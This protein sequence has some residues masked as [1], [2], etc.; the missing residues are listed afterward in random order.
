MD[1]REL[2]V[3]IRKDAITMV[4]EHHASHIASALSAVDMLA[5]LYADI[6]RID[7]HNPQW[8]A[9]DRFILSKGHA[10]VAVYAVLAETGFFPKE[11]LAQY[12]TNGSVYSGHV[13]H[14]GVPGVEFS[15]GSLGHGVCVAA[16]MALAAKK[17]QASYRVYTIIGDGECDEGSVWE[18]ALF[19]RQ[20]Q[21][22]N[23]I[24]LVDHNKMQAMGSCADIADLKDLA[25][26]WR[27][28]GWHVIDVP[29]GNDHAQLRKAL[30]S[31]VPDVPTC[32]VANTVKGKGVS[33]MENNILWHYRDPQDEA[34]E[35]AMK[36][37]EATGNA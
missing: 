30:Q 27:A 34:Y 26:K 23:L 25:E 37:L 22:G 7:P 20:Q 4:H 21:L 1:S 32:I 24:V 14:K 6:L 19:A 16:G 28:F 17:K 15:T 18:M 5:V 31:T 8:E 12:Y 9:R 10:G 3:N 29:D 13:S 36:E 33:F 2:A 11:N 35:Q